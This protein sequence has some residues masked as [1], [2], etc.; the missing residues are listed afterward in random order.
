MPTELSQN[1]SHTTRTSITT[2][3]ST[4][5]GKAPSAPVPVPRQRSP[6]RVCVV[7]TGQPQACVRL[8]ASARVLTTRTGNSPA[9]RNVLR[10]VQG[11]A[12]A[13]GPNRDGAE[14]IALHDL[15]HSAAGALDQVSRLLRQANPRVT[16]T[17]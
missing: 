7:T 13:A 3:R 8:A 2:R 10:A 16:T 17:F 6:A 9:R 11:A 14:P 12:I 5:T 1:A 4:G 15:R